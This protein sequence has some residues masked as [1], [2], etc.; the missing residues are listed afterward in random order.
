M[1]PSLVDMFSIGALAGFAM[2][3]CVFIHS[4]WHTQAPNILLGHILIPLAPLIGSIYY[5]LPKSTNIFQKAVTSA[6]GYGT[7]LFVSIVVYRVLFQRLTRAEFSGLTFARITKL[8]HVWAC[9][10]SQ[11]HLVLFDLHQEY[12]DFVRT[13]MYSLRTRRLSRLNQNL[14]PSEVTVFH[15]DVFEAI[16][17]LRSDCIKSEWYDILYPNLSLVTARVKET[18]RLRRAEWKRGFSAKGG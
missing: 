2:Q 12:G 5:G 10:R 16:D 14:G 4:E 6:F 9:R 18:H 17:G 1:D 3:L 11:N 15:P 13:G 7:A 8:W